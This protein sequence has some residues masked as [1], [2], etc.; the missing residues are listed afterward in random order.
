[1][2]GPISRKYPKLRDQLATNDV[3]TMTFLDIRFWIF[4]NLKMVK[5]IQAF[6]GDFEILIDG[7][8][9]TAWFKN[10]ERNNCCTKGTKIFLQDRKAATTAQRQ[11][12]AKEKSLL[13]QNVS[14]QKHIKNFNS[15]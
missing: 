11:Q 3:S 13:F 1:M 15:T 2:D 6:P 9:Q 7:R 8:E 14:K 4:E 12:D 10:H 5:K